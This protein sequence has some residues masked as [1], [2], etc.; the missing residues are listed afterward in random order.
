MHL[1]RHVILIMLFDLV[2]TTCTSMVKHVR[3]TS[4]VLCIYLN[5]F[6]RTWWRWFKKPAMRT[7]FYI[8]VFI[9]LFGLPIFC[10]WT[11]LMNIAT[12]TRRV[13]WIWYL[14]FYW[15]IWLS[16]L[17]PMNVPDE[18]FIRNVSR[19]LNLI[20]TYLLNYLTF[21]SFAYERTWWRC[22][23]KASRALNLISTYLLNYWTFQSFDYE[24]TWWRV[25][26]KRVARIK[27]YIYVFIKLFGFP[28]F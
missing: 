22:I 25:H 12:E 7:E 13:H 3:I 28:M 14:C 27:F 9:K 10:L 11:Y 4:T 23:R 6:Y 8:Y 5:V 21:Q 18:G 16:N 1:K 26:Q 15:I 2:Q 19:A 24:R 17:S 20:S